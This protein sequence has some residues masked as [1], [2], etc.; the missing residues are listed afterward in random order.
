MCVCAVAAIAMVVGESLDNLSNVWY[1]LPFTLILFL[2]ALCSPFNLHHWCSLHF[3]SFS[4]FAH[5]AHK[6]V[7]YVERFHEPFGHPIRAK[8]YFV[9]AFSC[10]GFH[11]K[12]NTKEYV[13][14][15]VFTKHKSDKL[16]ID[17]I[18]I[19]WIVFFLFFILCS[20]FVSPIFLEWKSNKWIIL[21][22]N[23]VHFASQPHLSMRSQSRFMRR[24]ALG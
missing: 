18:L 23:I 11:N 16:K 24:I 5:L 2:A 15:R 21:N 19:Q 4:V 14:T 13:N 3:L 1:L 10:N 12:Q 20:I 22:V 9:L 7:R 8:S 17:S 6:D